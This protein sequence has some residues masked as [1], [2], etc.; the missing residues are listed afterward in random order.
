VIGQDGD[1]YFYDERGTQRFVTSFPAKV[2]SIGISD[3]FHKGYVYGGREILIVDFINNQKKYIFFDVAF[4]GKPLINYDKQIIF[5]ISKEKKL[6]IYD[7]EGHLVKS[8][9]IERDY[10]RGLACESHG[11]IL[12]DDQELTGFSNEGKILFR[13][14]LKDRISDI[15][16]TGHTVVCSTKN[17]ALYNFNLSN[18]QAKEK[19]LNNKNGNLR[20]V[21]KN[22][23]FVLVS[24]KRLFY[25]DKD[26]SPISKHS[27]ESPD[28]HFFISG[29]DF[30][31]IIRGL[32]RFHCYDEKKNMVWR[33]TSD[34][35]IEESALMRSGLTFITENSIQ[36]V[37]IKNN[38]GSQKHFSEFLEF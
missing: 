7:F 32:D 9:P 22:P 24:K 10:Q 29:N 18:L 21:S 1:I 13:C 23:F 5:V 30:Y 37:A 36:Y 15:H 17:H 34:E 11:I 28:S 31:E 19:E 33:F 4:L 25:L 26:L 14:P 20:I 27:I 6:L 2:D 38:E 35:K 16:Y 12:F 8:V 3:D